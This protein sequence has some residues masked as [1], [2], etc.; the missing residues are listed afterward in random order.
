MNEQR[1]TVFQSGELDFAYDDTNFDSACAR[2]AARYG[3]YVKHVND[4]K[5]ASGWPVVRLV[6]TLGSVSSAVT[7]SWQSGDAETDREVALHA[8]ADGMWL[9]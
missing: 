5:D 9:E 8:I 2:M 4:A 1:P 7:E 6:G 3:V